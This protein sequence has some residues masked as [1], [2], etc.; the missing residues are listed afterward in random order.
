[1]VAPK[2]LFEIVYEGAACVDTEVDFFDQDNWRDAVRMCWACPVSESCHQLAQKNHERFGVWGG[3]PR[4]GNA[5]TK[6][7]Y[8]AIMEGVWA[9]RAKTGRP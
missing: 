4:H 1:M 3:V 9:S 5:R 6:K 2:T 8:L 7:K